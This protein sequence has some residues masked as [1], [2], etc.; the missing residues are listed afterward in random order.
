MTVGLVFSAGRGSKLLDSR[1]VSAI[2]WG[3]S[4]G[5]HSP[6]KMF[7]G[8]PAKTGWRGARGEALTKDSK[9]NR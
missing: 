9:T 7:F 8:L 2:T 4:I 3:L 6:A 1:Y 5:F